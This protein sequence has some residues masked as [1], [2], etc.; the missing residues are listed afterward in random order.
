ML[1]PIVLILVLF[2]GLPWLVLHYV[3]RWRQSTAL[4]PEDENLL[5]ELHEMTLRLEERLRT[6][7][8]LVAAEQAER[9]EARALTARAAAAPALPDRTDR[10]GPDGETAGSPR[11]AAEGG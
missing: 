8:R 3:S 11:P 6:V 10:A 2:L 7:E 1:I 5:D 9:A 4:T